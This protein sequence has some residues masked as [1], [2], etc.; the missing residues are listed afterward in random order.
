MAHDHGGHDQF[1]ARGH[2]PGHQHA[3]VRYDRAFAIGV[4]LNAGF[5]AVE[6]AAG[7]FAHSVALIADA[8]HNLSDVL[9]L[10]LAWGAAALARRSPTLRHTYGLR[11]SSILAALINAAILLVAI[12]AI[13]VETLRRFG[14]PEPVASGSV[15][16]V[17]AIGIGVNAATAWLFMA[18]RKSDLNIR[19]AYLHMA[20]DA[21]VSLGVVVAALAIGLTGWV[22]LDPAVSLAIVLVIAVGTWG[23][24]KDSIN[25]ALDAVPE[26]VDRGDVEAYLA[27]LPGISE[28]HDLHIWGL[29]TTD[30]A[31]TVHL[32]RPGTS[33][34]DAL[35]TTVTRE[36]HERFGI[37]HATFQMESDSCD[38]PCR[39]TSAHAA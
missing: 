35:I 22:W 34:D 6:A 20:A 18:G 10:L 14:E 37:N 32:V 27:A 31:L 30:T 26:H 15:M 8:G 24:L 13:A 28:V 38:H 9:G 3:P 29:S 33:A 5:V 39:L 16:L 21:A 1:H 25:L 2:A 11:R 23:L 19:G 7:V 17:A 4:A 12:G 36:L